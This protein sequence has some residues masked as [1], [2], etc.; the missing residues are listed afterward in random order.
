MTPD[1]RAI[2]RRR[3]ERSD[4]LSQSRC[5]NSRFARTVMPTALYDRIIGLAAC[6]LT[7]G[8]WCASAVGVGGAAGREATAAG[9]EA[10][11]GALAGAL[12]GAEGLIGVRRDFGSVLR[13]ET[14]RVERLRVLAP[15]LLVTVQHPDEDYR[16]GVFPSRY[17]S[18]MTVS[19]YGRRVNA[20]AMGH[21]RSVSSRIWVT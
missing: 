15:Y 10:F 3:V 16:A 7:S 1:G 5:C 17:L 11:S 9:R 14:V 6:L 4:G 20:G 18:P 12:R 8:I 19:L 21:S 13:A 2:S